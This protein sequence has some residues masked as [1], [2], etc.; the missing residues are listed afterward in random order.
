M[1]GF[2]TGWLNHAIA[3]IK[4]FLNRKR[5]ARN[6]QQCYKN[7]HFLKNFTPDTILGKNV[8][9]D[10]EKLMQELKASEIL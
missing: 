7:Q 4:G 2:V 3:L 9:T 8:S 6:L 5:R 1:F 10:H